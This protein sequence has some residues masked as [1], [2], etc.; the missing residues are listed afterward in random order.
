MMWITDPETIVPLIFS[1]VAFIAV[2]G[3][4]LPWI[5]PDIFASRLKVI[6]RRRDELSRARRQRLDQR[7]VVRRS[8]G[9]VD[10]MRGILE[11][12]NFK[13]LTQQ[14]ELKRKLVQAGWRGPGPP[15]T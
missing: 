7:I 12:L 14:P 10:L 2:V 9:R 4:G 15:V 1:A 6:K 3:L 11:R 5:Q 8:S 13:K